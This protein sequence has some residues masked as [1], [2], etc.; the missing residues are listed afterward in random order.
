MKLLNEYLDHA[1][2][3]ER[4]AE[5]EQKPEIRTQFAEQAKAYRKLAAERAAKYGLP[6][7]SLPAQPHD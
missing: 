3:F 1:L 5:Q 4:L 2:T 7:P 6:P